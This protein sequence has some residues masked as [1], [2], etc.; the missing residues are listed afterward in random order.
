[1]DND[2]RKITQK[3]IELLQIFKKNG[4][5]AYDKKIEEVDKENC[6]EKE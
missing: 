3:K 2:T 4:K 1:M 6:A 5:Y